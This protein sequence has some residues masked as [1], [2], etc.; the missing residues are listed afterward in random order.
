MK[1]NLFTGISKEIDAMEELI[2]KR[3][4]ELWDWKVKTCPAKWF[5]SLTDK[6]RKIVEECYK[7]VIEINPSVKWVEFIDLLRLKIH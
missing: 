2:G 7:I 6:E 4:H 1:K 5:Y 3:E